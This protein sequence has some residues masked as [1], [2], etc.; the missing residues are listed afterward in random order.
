ML[1]KLHSWTFFSLTLAL[2]VTNAWADFRGADEA[3]KT[4]N[5][6]K[7]FAECKSDADSGE[8]N[9]QSHVGFLYKYGFGVER[10]LAL[11]IDYL[12]RCANQGQMYC[13]EMLGDTYRNGIGTPQNFEEALR[14]FRSAAAKGNPWALN[15]MAN[16]YRYG[17]GVPKDPAEATK[18]FRAAADKG[19]GSSQASLADMYRLG[20]GVD[21]NPDEAFQWALK[22][23]KLNSGSGWNLLGLLY[24]DGVGVRQDSAQAIEAFKRAVHP[25]AEWPSMIAYA[26]LASMYYS[27]T[28]I[29]VNRDEAGKWA[30]EGV[31]NNNRESMLFLSNIL[32]QGSKSIPADPSRAFQLA[33]EAYKRGLVYAGENLG[34]YHRDGIGTAVDLVQAQR[35]YAEGVERGLPGA[36]VGLGRLY[37]EGK[38]VPKDTA[39]AEELLTIARTQMNRLSPGNKKFVENYFAAATSNLAANQTASVV[40]NSQTVVAGASTTPAPSPAKVDSTQQALLDR[41]EKMQKQLESLQASANTVQVNQ[42]MQAQMQLAPRKALVIGNDKY[43]HV[44]PLMN[45]KQDASAIANTL[46]KLG[47]SVT[48]HQ[49]LTEKA[50]KQALREFRSNLDGGDEVLFFFAGH[51]VQLGSSNFLLPTDIKGDN[52]D[53]V[54]D[55]AVELQRVLDDLKSKNTKFTLAIV[56]ACRDNPF[57][58]SGRAVGGRGLAPTTAATGQ[59]V[60]FSAGA[61]QQALD[62]LGETDKERNGVFTRVL[63][64][65]MSKPGVPVDRVLRNVRN[66]VVRLSKSIGHEQTPALYDQAVGD[67]YFAIK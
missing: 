31:K 25:S 24:R 65:E 57:K 62:K 59:M 50:F 56:D 16:M 11:S 28:G 2:S 23:S 37:L 15:N 48:L 4:K 12:K 58:K 49:D 40:G 6:S 7:V 54:K 47:Y 34:W 36:Y 21:K 67:F 10:N 60:M 64:R 39:K 53:Q 29:P 42:V 20:E 18:L 33:T 14:L 13:E 45:A 35:Y 32:V 26:N 66:E 1:K 55:E 63:L 51:G 19:N 43:Q 9:C 3:A 5:W 61:G 27:G 8:K 46:S 38:G 41:L 44:Q 52:E 22:S 30:Q 17:Q